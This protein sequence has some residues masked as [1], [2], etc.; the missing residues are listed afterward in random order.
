MILPPGVSKGLGLVRALNSLGLSPHN[1]IGVGDAENDHSLLS[2]CELGVAVSNAVDGLKR[3]ADLVLD[4]PGGRGVT[5]LLRSILQGGDAARFR[6]TRWMVELGR[7]VEGG[8]AAIAGSQVNLLITGRSKAGKSFVGGAFAERLIELGYSVCIIDPEGDYAS[9][10]QLHGVECLGP[11]GRLPDL[12]EI[13]R[14]LEHRFGSVIVDLSLIPQ[15]EHASSTQKLLRELAR[16]RKETGLPHWIIV[17]EAHHA[18]GLP[19]DLLASL[20]EGRKGYC[21]VTYQP[22]VLAERLKSAMDV[23]LVLPGGKKMAGPDPLA[24]VDRLCGLDISG[25]LEAAEPGQAAL[26]RLSNGQGIRLVTLAG[27]RTEHVRHWHK[28]LQARLPPGLRFVFRKAGEP[29]GT[30]ASNVEEFRELL[31][32]SVPEVVAHHAER[33]DFSRWIAEALQD[34][35]LAQAVRPIE[36][37]FLASNRTVGD[38]EALRRDVGVVIG[39][40]YVE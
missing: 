23:L 37:Q 28:Y 4:E 38:V 12:D 9:L 13:R 11:P 1:T 33:S 17:D 20:D 22:Q 18:L 36:R 21:L 2:I 25:R 14:L 24:E 32:A 5:G 40:R 19:G 29:G 15:A 26:V 7:F 8:R 10:G 3:H 39:Q 27:R 34:E 6:T 30:T 31:R 35:T 16:T